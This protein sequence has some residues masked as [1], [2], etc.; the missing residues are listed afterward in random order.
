MVKKWW[1][2]RTRVRKI[3]W[4][5]HLPFRVFNYYILS[6][7]WGTLVLH[8]QGP[9]SHDVNCPRS[10][11]MPSFIPLVHENKY[12]NKL[13]SSPWN[14][15][16]MS[17]SIGLLFWKDFFTHHRQRELLRPSY[18]VGRQQCRIIFPWEL[19]NIFFCNFHYKIFGCHTNFFT[20]QIWYCS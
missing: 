18:C 15:R 19:T 13:V 4:V 2:L 7:F 11:K 3:S 14:T 17:S 10:L 8:P 9:P 5:S 16:W 6:F 20:C 12:C 1:G